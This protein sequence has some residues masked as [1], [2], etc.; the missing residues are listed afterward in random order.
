MKNRMDSKIVLITGGSSGIGEG[1]ARKFAKE[2]AK[3]IL[4][5]RGE[6]RG[7]AVETAIREE[8]GEATFIPCDASKDEVVSAAVAQ[9][10]DIYGA[11]NILVNNAGGGGGEVFP[12]ET[13]EEWDR[14]IRANLYSTFFVSRAVWPHLVE[15]SGRTL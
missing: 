6:E 1:T 14:V 15:L 8:G 3:V 11:I 4:M 7:K 12:D 13:N 9:A 2:G 10:A 5:A